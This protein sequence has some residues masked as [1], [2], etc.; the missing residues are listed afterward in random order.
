[1]DREDIEYESINILEN[2]E[3]MERVRSLGFSS[4]PV[5]VA[6]ETNWSGFRAERIKGLKAAK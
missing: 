5:V 3:G 4:V 1:M 6:G 2:D